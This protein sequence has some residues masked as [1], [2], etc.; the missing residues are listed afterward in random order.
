VSVVCLKTKVLRNSYHQSI[1]KR[2]VVK[3][4][5]VFKLLAIKSLALSLQGARQDSTPQ[6]LSDWSWWLSS[7]DGGGFL[8]SS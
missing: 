1:H 6:F 4:L 3:F 2:V 5:N 7:P 8:L